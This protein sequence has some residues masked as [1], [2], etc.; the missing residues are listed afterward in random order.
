MSTLHEQK[1]NQPH[2]TRHAKPS[3]GVDGGGSVNNDDNQSIGNQS[4]QSMRSLVS[5]GGLIDRLKGGP[6]QGQ[7]QGQ[8]Q[9]D[10]R[11]GGL[12][13][14]MAFN[15]SETLTHQPTPH[16]HHHA[17]MSQG[18]GQGPSGNVIVPG[19]G[20]NNMG[21]RPMTDQLDSPGRDLL[22]NPQ[23]YRHESFQVVPNLL[24]PFSFPSCYP[25][26]TIISPLIPTYLSHTL[27]Y[28]LPLSLSISLCFSW[29]ETATSSKMIDRRWKKRHLR[30]ITTAH[31][32][33]RFID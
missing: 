25:F 14:P 31:W 33:Q 29:E 23:L 13:S 1:S 3:G 10:N 11:M 32:S 15:D 21:V 24:T 2:H 27:P 22:D 20:V 19:G 28:S 18:Q 7:G 9:G 12:A 4:V 17:T 30:D 26:P 5:V 16:Y 8:G 6:G